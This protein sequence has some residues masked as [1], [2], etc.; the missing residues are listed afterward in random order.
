MKLK[1]TFVL[2]LSLL[3]FSICIPKLI[4]AEET[5]NSEFANDTGTEADE[6]VAQ[7]TIWLGLKGAI[8]FNLSGFN[9]EIGVDSLF[10][11]SKI[12]GL[13]L[14]AGYTYFKTK[15]KET[16]W[17]FSSSSYSYSYENH[18]IYAGIM[19]FFDINGWLPYI[20]MYYQKKLGNAN[21][22]IYDS[23]YAHFIKIK[24]NY[25]LII[26]LISF[27]KTFDKMKL[28]FSVYSRIGF[29]KYVSSETYTYPGY[30]YVGRDPGLL[31][32]L[33]WGI[34]GSVSIMFSVN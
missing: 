31:F 34:Y 2:S 20:G 19:L 17:L 11:F 33:Y 29:A 32:G 7:K 15:E 5:D 4:Y 1:T 23:G 16:S 22:T 26:S 6:T 27:T 13:R 12:L 18:S 24:E 9:P 14:E 25:G 28:L 21:F 3:F 10:Y 30:T 8:G